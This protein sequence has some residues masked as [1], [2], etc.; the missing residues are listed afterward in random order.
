MSEH[1][2][3][4]LSLCRATTKVPLYVQEVDAIPITA[5]H[6]AAMIVKRFGLCVG[7]TLHQG[8][9]ASGWSQPHAAA[10]KLP[11]DLLKLAVCRIVPEA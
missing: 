4:R 5:A 6:S 2:H 7:G 11:S 1:Q 9:S 8:L 3:I 10:M